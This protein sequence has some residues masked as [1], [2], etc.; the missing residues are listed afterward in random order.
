M[1]ALNQDAIIL[2]WVALNKQLANIKIQEMKLRKEIAEFVLEENKIE[3]FSKKVHLGNGYGLK[4]TQVLNYKIE[5]P[6]KKLGDLT[7]WL[8]DNNEPEV[9]QE[10]IEFNESAYKKLSPEAKSFVDEII[11][12]KIGSPKLEFIVPKEA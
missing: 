9:F 11:S 5:D 2:Q 8:Y 1:D 7:K 12:C 10:K 3:A 4:A 6:E